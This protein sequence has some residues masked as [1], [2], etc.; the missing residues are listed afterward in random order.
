M[1]FKQFTV[2]LACEYAEMFAAVSES[3]FLVRG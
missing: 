3:V 2:W 1:G